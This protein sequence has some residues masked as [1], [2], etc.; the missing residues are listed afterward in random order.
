MKAPARKAPAKRDDGLAEVMALLVREAGCPT[1]TPST[2]RIGGREV[3]RYKLPPWDRPQ[4]AWIAVEDG[5]GIATK[6]VVDQPPAELEAVLATPVE[7]RAGV[8]TVKEA[9]L[10][11]FD[12]VLVVSADDLGWFP[13]LSEVQLHWVFPCHRC[14]VP[15]GMP[16]D[17]FD[18]MLRKGAGFH[19]QLLDWTREPQP[20]LRVRC[21]S[22]K[23]PSPVRRYGKELGV[24]SFAYEAQML[25]Q[26]TPAG[27]EIEVGNVRGET[28]TFR[29]HAAG[30]LVGDDPAPIPRSAAAAALRSFLLRG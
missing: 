26:C 30:L 2:V 21:S 28:L 10:G 6:A 12:R 9:R 23:L 4:T 15:D 27:V 8:V 25:E 5:V 20:F 14:E 22:P 17:E 16:I 3:A 29:G 19:D 24:S 7:P 11:R 1:E 18:F 13:R